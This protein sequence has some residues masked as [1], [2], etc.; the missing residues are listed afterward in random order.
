MS[1]REV[2]GKEVGDEGKREQERG[3]KKKR[4]RGREED[5]KILLAKRE[6]L[7]RTWRHK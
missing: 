6:I 7:T 4:E 1:R 3:E 2:E 5:R